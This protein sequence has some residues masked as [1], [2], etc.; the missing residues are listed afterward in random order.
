M[1]VQNKMKA[2][3]NTIKEKLGTSTGVGL[4]FMRLVD[5]R[6]TL[7]PGF[8]FFEAEGYVGKLQK[9]ATVRWATGTAL[10]GTFSCGSFKAMFRGHPKAALAE[11]VGFALLRLHCFIFYS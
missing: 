11:P 3:K 2:R 4:R 10:P 6:F 7:F 8:G 1:K 9:P 5:L